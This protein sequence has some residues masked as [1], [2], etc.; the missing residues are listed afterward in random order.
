LSR[1][2]FKRHAHG[3]IVARFSGAAGFFKSPSPSLV[4]NFGLLDP[5]HFAIEARLKVS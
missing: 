5:T 1:Y 3:V 4:I 2:F